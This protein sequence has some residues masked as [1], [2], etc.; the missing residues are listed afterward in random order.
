[1]S[2]QIMTHI[3]AGYPSLEESEQI[4]LTMIEAGVNHLEIQIPFSDP[5]ADGP[6]IS[7][8]NHAALEAGIKLSDLSL[9]HI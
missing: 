1:M 9:I 2:Y 3:V 8:A 6:V 7:Q 4:A 5:V